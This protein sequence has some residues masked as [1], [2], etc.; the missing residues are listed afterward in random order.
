[1]MY[2]YVLQNYTVHAKGAKEIKIRSIGYKKQHVTM[3]LFKTAD[4]H[5]LLSYIVLSS[6]IIP[7]N[8]AS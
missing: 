1:M 8:E 4:G 5:K 6:K 2:F 7:K 3:M